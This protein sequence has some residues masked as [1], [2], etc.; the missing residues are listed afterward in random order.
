[1]K[2]H[3]LNEAFKSINFLKNHNITYCIVGASEGVNLLNKAFFGVNIALKID[4]RKA[5]DTIDQNFLINVLEAFRFSLYFR[6]WILSL[7][8]S[9][10]FSILINGQSQG[11]F[12]YSRGVRQGDPLSPLLFCLVED[13]LSRCI[14]SKTDQGAIIPMLQTRNNYFPTYFLYVDDVLLFGKATV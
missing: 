14:S 2:L 13:F 5:F 8:S 9:A 3:L 12:S 11:Y 1:M 4:I 7:F 6:D 10:R